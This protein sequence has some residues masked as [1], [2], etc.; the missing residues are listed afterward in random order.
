MLVENHFPQDTR[1]KN[2][3]ILLTESG[4]HVL[5]DRTSKKRPDHD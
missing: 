5:S 3:A 1:V 4:Y 2:E